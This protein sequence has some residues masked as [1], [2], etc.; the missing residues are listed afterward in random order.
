MFPGFDN[1]QSV[2]DVLPPGIHDV[3]MD[4]IE[5]HFASNNVRKKLFD[6][7]KQ[8]VFNLQQAGCSHIFLDGSFVTKKENPGDYDVCWDPTGVDTHKLDPVFLDFTNQRRRQKIK[9]GGEFFPSSACAD[10]TQ[11]FL[12]FFQIDKYTGNQKGLIR[13]R[14]P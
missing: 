13:I 1:I 4:E 10:G 3:T 9:Y 5:Q 8:A 7:L 14:L 6:G 12:E 11:T 2:W